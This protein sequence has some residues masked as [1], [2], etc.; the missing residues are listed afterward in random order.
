MTSAQVVLKTSGLLQAQ[1]VREYFARA[2]FQVGPVVGISFS[3]AGSVTQFEQSFGVRADSTGERPFAA[4]ELPLTAL[5]PA[6]D[7]H[8]QAV[9]FSRP[10]DFG[11]GN[12]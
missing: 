7:A 8:V 10:P 11:P 3:I 2:G 1:L 12:P 9:L 5:D 6:L 4:D